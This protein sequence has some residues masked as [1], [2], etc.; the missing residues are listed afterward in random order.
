LEIYA[1]QP[2]EHKR[3]VIAL[4]DAARQEDGHVLARLQE[5]LG[6]PIGELAESP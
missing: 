6:R 2:D 4:F 3:R 1:A 5:S